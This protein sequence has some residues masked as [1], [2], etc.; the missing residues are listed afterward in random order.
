MS[1]NPD[2]T[3]EKIKQTGKK[4]KKRDIEKP[5]K[6]VLPIVLGILFLLPA[7][8]VL[9]VSKVIPTTMTIIGS[10][11][12]SRG[13]NIF[14]SFVGIEN[15]RI[16]F[17][18]PQFF[19]SLEFTSLLILVRV[20]VILFPTLPLGLGA[21]SLKPLGR[22]I[23]RILASIP[24]MVY[25]PIALGITW[26]LLLNPMFGFGNEILNLRDPEK[27][28]ILILAIDG[29][30]FLGLAGGLGVTAFLS[31]LKG[32]NES[33]RRKPVKSVLLIEALM[34]L[35]TVAFTVQG[36]STINFVAGGGVN[37]S[38]LTFQNLIFRFLFITFRPGLSSAIASVLFLLVMI[39]GIAAALILIL[40]H[41]RLFALSPKSNPVKYAKWFKIVSIILLIL[42]LILQL[43][44]VVPYIAKFIPLF[45]TPLAN[46]MNDTSDLVQE[47][48]FWRTLLNT[49]LVPFVIVILVQ[50]P[51]TYVAALGI[52]ALRP[53]GK[54][55]EWLLIIF[56][57][58][59][60][61]T[62]LLVIPGM[63]RLINSVGINNNLI[64]FSIPYLLNIPMLFILVLFFRGQHYKFVENEKKQ[65]FF[66]KFV[67]P[68]IPLT[69]F[70]LIFSMIY[71]Q[72]D[73]VWV[74]SL[75]MTQAQQF[76]PGLIRSLLTAGS[77][78][79]IGW[80]LA[81]IRIPAFILG[82]LVFGGF[83]L[84]YF[85]RLG[86]KSGKPTLD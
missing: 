83:Q 40:S 56:A 55:S 45:R 16:F 19:D 46:I 31:A 77:E 84:F 42:F 54:G 78:R 8:G 70:C 66:T 81:F 85:P 13:F 50:F 71:I 49:W 22:K 52:G 57:P 61:M 4:Q 41:F 14:G 9:V 37:N 33:G 64:T 32:E 80:L 75:P 1:E 39:L 38:T 63:L 62:E 67:W 21:G 58:W 18:S 2:K 26:I 79:T 10:F 69:A 59:L 36:G 11:Q 15:Y 44:S 23:V 6:R 17:A 27:G 28:R 20:I 25:S 30:S 74:R 82:F 60:I 43:I 34:L 47:T 3:S 76:I 24:W 73:M 48:L 12:E 65:G 35:V 5:S 53:L 29:L 7:L 68:S 51:I 72:Q 86:I